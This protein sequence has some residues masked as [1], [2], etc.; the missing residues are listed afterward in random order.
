LAVAAGC[1][2]WQLWSTREREPQACFAVFLHNHW[3]GLAIF[4]GIVADYGLR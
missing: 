4:L 3:V 2:A 1:F